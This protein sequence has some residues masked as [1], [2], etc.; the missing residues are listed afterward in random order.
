M[1]ALGFV[2]F[3]TLVASF[4]FCL[5]NS[6]T[7]PF[8]HHLSFKL[9]DSSEHGRHEFAGWRLGVHAEVEDAYPDA[10]LLQR[11]EDRGL[12]HPAGVHPSHP[13]AGNQQ[14]SA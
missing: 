11:I 4:R 7:L 14:L 12:G 1:A 13:R 8:Q 10:L 6:F 5:G 9:R 3:A 2:G